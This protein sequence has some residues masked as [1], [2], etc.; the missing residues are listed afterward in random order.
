MVLSHHGH[1]SLSL[2]I[3]K[4]RGKR[5]QVRLMGHSTVDKRGETSREEGAGHPRAAAAHRWVSGLASAP[6]GGPTQQS[7]RHH[8]SELLCPAKRSP[9]KAAGHQVQGRVLALE[10]QVASV[11]ALTVPLYCTL[12]FKHHYQ[13]SW[14]PRPSQGRAGSSG[15]SPWGSYGGGGPTG[16][17]P[18]WHKPRFGGKGLAV[19]TKVRD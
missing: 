14:G 6:P 11:S 2:K 16:R 9:S 5:E 12:F 1:V 3:N 15:P 18:H 13:G 17:S 7:A 19:N 4:G 8:R 10:V